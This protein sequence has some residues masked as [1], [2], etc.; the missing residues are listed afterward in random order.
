MPELYE[1]IV[2]FRSF[3]DDRLPYAFAY[4]CFGTTAV[5]RT[6]HNGNRGIPEIREGHAPAGFGIGFYI[7]NG[8]SGITRHEDLYVLC[9][10]KKSGGYH[11]AQRQTNYF[12]EHIALF[13][14]DKT[15][16]VYFKIC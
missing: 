3:I 8:H 13:L 7:F 6:I 14:V 10:W 12:F 4:E 2:A 9:I 5:L 15:V 11:Q 16:Q 1:H